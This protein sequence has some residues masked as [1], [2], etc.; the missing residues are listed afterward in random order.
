MDRWR[1]RVALVTGASDGIGAAVLKALSQSGLKVVGCAR[2]VEMIQSVAKDHENVY[3]YKCDLSDDKA[4]EEMF[5]WIESQPRLGKVDVCV[6]N[7]GLS[8]A[9][10]LLDGDYSEWREQMNVNVL[11]MAQCTQLAIKS[12]LKNNIKDGQIV[13]TSSMSAHRVAKSNNT[14]FYAATKFAVKA[15]FEGFR[16]EIRDLDLE[17][18]RIRICCI[19]PGVVE[20]GYDLVQHRGDSDLAGISYKTMSPLQP[21]DIAEQVLHILRMPDYVEINDIHIRPVKQVF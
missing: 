10:T 9:S 16:Q 18:N 6:A 12:M 3:P 8:R 20:T 11:A 15:L 1:D 19:S 2:R 13:V 7:A 5:A 4:V 14:R 17:G 21:E